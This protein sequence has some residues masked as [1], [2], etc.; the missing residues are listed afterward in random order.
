MKKIIYSL[1]VL[2]SIFVLLSCKTNK[3]VKCDA[4]SIKEQEQ[5]Q[6][7]NMDFDIDKY[8]IESQKKYS[9]VTSIRL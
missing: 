7:Y 6:N 4:Y 2:S 9:T 1:V 5:E 3:I 8:N